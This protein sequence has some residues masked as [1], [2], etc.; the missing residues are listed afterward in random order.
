M[1][2]PSFSKVQCL[3]ASFVYA[4][5][6]LGAQAHAQAATPGKQ[7]DF[8]TH[9][10]FFSAETKQKKALD[11]QVFVM[12]PSAP[13]AAGPQ[14]IKHAAGVR[15]A[16]ISDAANT[17]IFNAE[18]RPLDMSLGQ[19]LGAT[20]HVILS[21][22]PDGKERVTVAFSG[23]KPGGHYSLFENH[24]DQQ[25]IGFTPLDGSGS[26]NSFV[27]DKSGRGVSTVI[28]P[29]ALSHDNAVLLVYHS[30]GKTH[31]KSRGDIGVNAHHQLIARPK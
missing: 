15:T 25:P 7:L 26:D 18:I 1:Y 6:A 2:E 4:S 5:L 17:S 23:L 12:E 8:G 10:E 16:W 24:F 11:P 31:G 29:S 22:M 14:G 27:A 30:D 13:A 28:A 20:G 21:S 3:L 9:A 19:W